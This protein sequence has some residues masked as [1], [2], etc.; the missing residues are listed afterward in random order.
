ML[1]LTADL[2][3]D[4]PTASK[5]H[6]IC[7]PFFNWRRLGQAQVKPYGWGVFLL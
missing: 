3:F 6:A 7:L 4:R 1:H 5:V 2:S